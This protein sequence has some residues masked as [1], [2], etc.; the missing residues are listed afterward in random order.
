MSSASGIAPSA[1]PPVIVQAFHD[2]LLDDQGRHYLDLFS[3]FGACLLGHG[4]PE[5]VQGLAAQVQGPWLLGGLPHP[6]TAQLVQAF[7]PHLPA[8]MTLASLTSTGM[9]AAELAIRVARV[10]SG[11]AGALGFAGSMHGKSLATAYLGWDNH[12]GVQLPGW[13]R[14]PFVDQADEAA[15]LA[16]AQQALG[17]GQI[18]AVFVET[19]Q[20]SNGAHEASTGFYRQLADMTRRAGALLVCD[21]ILTGFYR[22][23]VRFRFEHHGLQPDAVLVGKAFA[24]GFPAAGLLLA[25]PHALQPRMLPGST[26]AGNPLACAAVA[27]TLQVMGTLDLPALA[28]EVAAVVREQFQDL[29]PGWALRGAGALWVLDCVTPEAGRRMLH[30]AFRSGVA[31]GAYGRWLRIMPAA[32]VD[33]ARLAQACARLSLAAR[34]ASH[35]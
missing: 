29:P 12:D 31:V 25:R 4:R 19:M 23:G 16:D 26:F 17:S 20:G 2:T 33:R 24:N 32:T 22:T 34:E 1:E 30:A 27:H 6:Q 10:I 28:G 21:E 13:Q 18:G 11:R 15:I 35:A 9:E 7:A 3:G 8:G 5:V 14:L